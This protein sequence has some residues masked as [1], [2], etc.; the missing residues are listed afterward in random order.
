M[1]IDHFGQTMRQA[2][3]SFPER[4]GRLTFGLQEAA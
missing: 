3:T 4:A 2:V 1:L